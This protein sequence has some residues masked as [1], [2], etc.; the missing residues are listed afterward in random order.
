MNQITDLADL[1]KSHKRK[2]FCAET[3]T[4][5]AQ[6]LADE[7]DT[8]DIERTFE[9]LEWSRFCDVKSDLQLTTD[10]LR[11]KLDKLL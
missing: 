2:L 7:W 1:I 5:Y 9:E 8:D 10:E 11:A 6:Q 4:D 3:D